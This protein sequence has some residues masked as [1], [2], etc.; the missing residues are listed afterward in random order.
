MPSCYSVPE[1]YSLFSGVTLN[2]KIKYYIFRNKTMSNL[3]L[4]VQRSTNKGLRT[5][6]TTH[7]ESQHLQWPEFLVSGILAESMLICWRT[8]VLILFLNSQNCVIVLFSISK[9]RLYLYFVW[10]NHALITDLEIGL[11]L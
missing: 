6:S 9:S 4:P 7:I 1:C 10:L 5:M 8:S 11:G 2:T 3:E